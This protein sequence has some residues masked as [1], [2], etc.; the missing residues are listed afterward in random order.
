MSAPAIK[1][2]RVLFA[3]LVVVW[4]VGADNCWAAIIKGTITHNEF[5]VGHALEVQLWQLNPE[6]L[7]YDHVG[8]TTYDPATG[9]Y[10]FTDLSDGSYHLH[11]LDLTGVYAAE[12]Y[13]DVYAEAD[14]TTV[15]I[16]NGVTLV[17]PVNI[18]VEPGAVIS[19]TVTGAGVGPLAGI[20]IGIVEMSDPQG[21]PLMDV[22]YYIGTDPN[23]EFK[24]GL[25][26]GIYT[27]S[28]WDYSDNPYWA[29]QQYSNTVAHQWATPVVLTSVGQS[30]ININAT[31]QPGYDIS[32]TV[33]DNNG[34]KLA[35]VFASFE[36]YD[37]ARM[38][39]GTSVS[40]RTDENGFY[41][42]NF[43]PGQYRVYFEENSRL[44]EQEY[45]SNA[46]LPANAASVNLSSSSVGGIDA[47][48]EHTP[49]ARWA[50]SYGL[51][52]FADVEGWLNQDPDADTYDNFHEFAFGTDPINP[53]S[54]NPIQ[55]NPPRRLPVGISPLASN[56]VTFSALFH[57]NLS[58]A[59]WLQYE[60]QYKTNLM[61]P[62]WASEYL[63]IPHVLP[64]DTSIMQITCTNHS[65]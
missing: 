58:T 38:E 17:D 7:I 10:E 65:L 57:Q 37:P 35:G 63:G 3:A 5:P 16:E 46:M 60:L 28:F 30:T 19:G 48:L 40:K 64:S 12:V 43:P 23:G 59:Y 9:Q 52:P 50:F 47:Q 53:S 42:V 49:L 26:P 31:L 25:R 21:M 62:G 2:L 1:A 44:Y 22:G 56:T 34:V 41:S 13:E 24:L 27:V 45:W 61:T 8:Q 15:K 36:V 20:A 51:D 18:E 11:V 6:T 4:S 55:I 14:A 32:G 54:G 39:W 29:T 33:T